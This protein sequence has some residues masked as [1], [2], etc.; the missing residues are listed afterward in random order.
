[1]DALLPPHPP[2][3]PRS[4]RRGRAQVPSPAGGQPAKLSFSVKAARGLWPSAKGLMVMLRLSSERQ[5][6]HIRPFIFTAFWFTPTE[7]LKTEPECCCRLDRLQVTSDCYLN[8]RWDCRR[9]FSTCN[10]TDICT[11]WMQSNGCDTLD[12][13]RKQDPCSL[14]SSVSI[15]DSQPQTELQGSAGVVLAYQTFLIEVMKR[16]ESL[17]G[18]GNNRRVVLPLGLLGPAYWFEL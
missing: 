10:K 13:I 14:V 5:L 7:P 2:P 17:W 16:A 8:W 11:R 3:P 4:S 9:S 18:R 12:S 15:Q 6:P 1:M